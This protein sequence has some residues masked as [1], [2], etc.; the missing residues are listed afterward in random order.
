MHQWPEV[1]LLEVQPGDAPGNNNASGEL[2]CTGLLNADMP[3][4][5][6]RV[7]DR[8]TVRKNQD[9]CSCG[10]RLPLLASIDG[11]V[12]DVLFT[13]DGRR[14]GRLD[15]VFK[16]KLPILEAQIIQESL[17]LIKV[18][19]VPAQDYNTAAGDSIVERLRERMG[20][21]EVVLEAVAE[22]PRGP[23]GKFRGVI[24]QLTP[25]DLSKLAQV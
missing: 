25:E 19:Y 15:P 3:F 13:A 9:L 8:A 5:R 11:R 2:V 21:I 18:R 24:C 16:T 12:D 17:N 14:I 20:P 10:R 22:I 1:G 7:G 6:Y 4:V 23:N